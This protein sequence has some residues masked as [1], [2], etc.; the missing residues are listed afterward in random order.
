MVMVFLL[1]FRVLCDS[2]VIFFFSGSY[3]VDH[4]TKLSRHTFQVTNENKEG[5]VHLR[6]CT[7]IYTINCLLFGH[8]PP[9]SRFNNATHNSNLVHGSRGVD[10]D[11]LSRNGHLEP[12]A[13]PS[14]RVSLSPT[15]GEHFS[16]VVWM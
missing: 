1:V 4:G 10:H 3:A 8:D 15:L 2:W 11:K 12:T 14:E 5:D 9:A 16:D 13:F 7:V 6:R